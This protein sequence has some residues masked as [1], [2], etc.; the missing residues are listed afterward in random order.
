MRYRFLSLQRAALG[1]LQANAACRGR[2]FW[3]PGAPHARLQGTRIA[4]RLRA[5]ALEPSHPGVHAV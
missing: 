4:G 3:Q 2:A 5:W 1:V